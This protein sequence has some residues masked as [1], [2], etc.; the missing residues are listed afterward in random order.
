MLR[1]NEGKVGV[2]TVSKRRSV[3]ASRSSAKEDQHR[4]MAGEKCEDSRLLAE[5][6]SGKLTSRDVLEITRSSSNLFLFEM[7]LEERTNKSNQK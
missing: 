6:H 7:G 4:R 2:R 5:L 3:Y 1:R